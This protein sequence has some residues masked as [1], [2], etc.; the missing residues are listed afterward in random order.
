M[1]SLA[2]VKLTWHEAAIGAEIGKLRRLTSIK[3][4]RSQTA[5]AKLGWTE[6]IEGACAELALAKYLGIYWN[7]SVDTFKSQPDVGELEVRHTSY[8]NGKLIVRPHD[9][10]TATFV[11]IVGT[12]PEYRIVGTKVGLEAKRPEWLS[13]PTSANRP[14]AYFVPQSELKALGL[15][16][17]TLDAN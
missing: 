2:L 13:D 8:P 4:G 15:V 14:S 5:G 7:G 6:D 16:S 11:L 17:G 12:C 1:D 9:S 10:D 3:N